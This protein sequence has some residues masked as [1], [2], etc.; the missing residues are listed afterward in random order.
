MKGHHS[1]YSLDNKSTAVNTEGNF[2]S[3]ERNSAKLKSGQINMGKEN[4]T[5]TAWQ[6]QGAYFL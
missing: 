2:D 3:A 5:A 6:K 4:R 1:H